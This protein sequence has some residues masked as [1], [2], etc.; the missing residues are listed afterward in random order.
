M[1]FV[2]SHTRRFAAPAI[3]AALALF[4]LPSTGQAEAELVT[5]TGTI[6]VAEGAGGVI[7]IV[8]PEARYVVTPV[9]AAARLAK[10]P[11]KTVTAKGTIGKDAAGNPTLAITE[12]E[13]AES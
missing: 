7:A 10:H 1:S 9:A 12:F 6:E 5:V 8:S 3:I 13:V 4:A 11:G 2:A